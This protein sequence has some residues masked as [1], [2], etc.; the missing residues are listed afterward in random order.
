MWDIERVYPSI[1]ASYCKGGC[2]GS[3]Q[4]CAECPA[5]RLLPEA[6]PGYAAYLVCATQWRH[7][8]TGSR[9]G[10]DY[11]ACQGLLQ[12]YLPRWREKGGEIFRDVT[13]DELMQDIQI[14]E[15]S[16]LQ[17]DHEKR[18]REQDARARERITIGN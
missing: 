13:L 11:T 17:V 3:G 7:G 18:E 6:Q 15:I 4:R 9:S 16:I 14:M 1:D 12:T 10:L 8:G 5:P 2:D